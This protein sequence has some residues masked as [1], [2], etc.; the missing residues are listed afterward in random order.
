[1]GAKVTELEDRQARFTGARFAV[2]TV[3]GTAALHIAL[4]L[5]G[6]ERGDEVITQALTFVATCNAVS[7]A[8]PFRYSLTW[9]AIPS[10]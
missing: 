1:V 6:V 4:Q 7:Y 2:A 8:G 10:G 9:T 5:A 3:N